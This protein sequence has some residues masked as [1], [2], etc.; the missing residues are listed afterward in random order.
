MS[1]TTRYDSA[2]YLD[3]PEAVAEY[4][5]AALETA[6]ASFIARAIGTAARAHGMSEIARESG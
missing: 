1:K 6:D 3:S 5:T 4:L 2:E